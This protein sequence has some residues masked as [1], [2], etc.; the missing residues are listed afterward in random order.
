MKSPASLATPEEMI[1]PAATEA[2]TDSLEMTTVKMDLPDRPD[3]PVAAEAGEVGAE[4]AEKIRGT[5][6]D[7]LWSLATSTVRASQLRRDQI[8]VFDPCCDDPADFGVV[9]SGK[10][11]IYRPIYVC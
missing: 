8:G 6:E 3:R 9:A 10:D 2:A 5:R 1:L 4:E 11:F 7:S